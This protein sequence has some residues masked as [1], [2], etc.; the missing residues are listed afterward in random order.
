MDRDDTS[1]RHFAARTKRPKVVANGPVAEVAERHGI[2][3]V[4]IFIMHDQGFGTVSD[5]VDDTRFRY[6]GTS[7]TVTKYAGMR[8]RRDQH[9]AMSSAFKI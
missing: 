9:E 3:P 8:H 1:I 4:N 2:V 6:I 7:P 5:Q